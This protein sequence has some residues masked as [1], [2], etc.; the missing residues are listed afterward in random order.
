MKDRGWSLTKVTG[1][2]TV[3]SS[4]PGAPC[5]SSSGSKKSLQNWGK[6]DL[7]SAPQSH[8]PVCSG[9][10]TFIQLS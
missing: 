9:R 10:K 1:D 2:L 8:L 6:V 5:F 4:S 3:L 7:L